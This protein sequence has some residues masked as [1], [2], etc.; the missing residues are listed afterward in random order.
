M[1][2]SIRPYAPEDREAVIALSLRAWEPVHASLARVL[3]ARIYDRTVGDWCHSQSRDVQ[4]DLDAEEVRVWVA[5]TGRVAGFAS[6]KLNREERTGEV[7]MLAVDPDQQNRG[8]GSRLTEFAEEYMRAEGMTVAVIETGG[9]PGHAAARSTYERA[10]F[11]QL[12][13]A[14]YFKAL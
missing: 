8:V 5:V 7:H 3:G 2:I 13:I 4:A 9:D 6:V 12:P 11:T 10:G 14:R 1:D